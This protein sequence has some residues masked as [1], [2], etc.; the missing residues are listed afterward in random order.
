VKFIRFAQWRVDRTGEGVIG[1]VTDR[2]YLENPTFR[3]MRRSLLESFSDI[4]IYDLH[5]GLKKK[6]KAPNG[7]KDVNVF[8]IL[9]GVAILLCVKEQNKKGRANVHHANLWGSREHKYEVLSNSDVSGT[10]WTDISPAE[11]QNLFV[12]TKNALLSEYERGWRLPDVFSLNGDPAPG[13]V[14]THDEFAI[15]FT[16]KEIRG[17]VQSVVDTATEADARQIFKLCGTTQWDYEDAK[18]ELADGK[19]KQDISQIL[20]RP[21]DRRWTVFNSH[22][23]V[24]R[25]ERVMQHMLAGSNLGIITTRNIET[26]YQAHVFCS[27]SI[28]GHHAVSLKEVNYL[29][30]LFLYPKEQSDQPR[31]DDHWQKKANI[32]PIF[33][34]QIEERLAQKSGLTDLPQEVRPEHIF[35]YIYAVMHSPTYRTRYAEFLK[36]DFARIPL[37]ADRRLFFNLADKG[38][39]L[40]ALHL[41]K[42]ADAP[43]VNQFIT[44]FRKPGTNVVE[45]VEYDPATR[46]VHINDKQYF[47]GVPSETWDFHI[48]DYKVCERW[49]KDRKGRE[50]SYDDVQHW[51]RVVVALTETRRLMEEIDALIPDWPLL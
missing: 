25:R 2:G 40:V 34:T 46:H 26:G 29:L 15:A 17:N 23:A 8:D 21:F 50:L 44:K 45:K 47:E 33:V 10:A 20:Y 31:L 42:E 41:L 37:T 43:R 32:S 51:Q 9:Q 3:G 12:P 1:Y 11:P 18:A 14:T 16:E 39:E 48:G 13:I 22:V 30:P 49:L 38:E 36:R 27:D 5:G 28:V 6:E 7:E 4:Y 24:H 19:W 35:Y